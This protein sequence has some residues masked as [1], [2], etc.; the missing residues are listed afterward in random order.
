M[1]KDLMEVH[2]WFKLQETEEERGLIFQKIAVQDHKNQTCVS[3]A[4]NM[5]TGITSY[6]LKNK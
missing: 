2:W 1:G 5:D 3:I 6:V 4:K